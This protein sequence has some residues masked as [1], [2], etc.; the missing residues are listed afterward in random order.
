M[1]HIASDLMPRRLLLPCEALNTLKEWVLISSES[2]LFGS[3]WLMPPSPPRDTGTRRTQSGSINKCWDWFTANTV[4]NVFMLTETE[5][6][7]R[8]Y[9]VCWKT[10]PVTQILIWKETNQVI[11]AQR[12]KSAG[13]D[14]PSL[15]SFTCIKKIKLLLLLLWSGF[16]TTTTCLCARGAPTSAHMWRPH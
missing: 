5:A 4:N 6:D 16:R 1:P 12:M 15:V 14:H 7:G 2:L 13:W 11:K 8:Y 10:V 3:E 9:S